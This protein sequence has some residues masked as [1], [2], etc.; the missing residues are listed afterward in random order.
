MNGCPRPLPPIVRG[1]LTLRPVSEPDVEP[2]ARRIATDPVTARWWSP[3]FET[4]LRWLREML[5]DEFVIEVEGDVAGI[6]AF[7][8]SHEPEYRFA[9]IDIALF[10]EFIGRGLGPLAIRTLGRWLIDECGHHR[11]TIDPSVDNARAIRAYEKVGF[12]RIGVLR[13]YERQQ[14]GTWGDNLY[15]DLLA[16]EL[17]DTDLDD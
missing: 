2:L 14:D 3:V 4:N 12:R 10:G 16:E 8:D 5:P 17:I 9:A 1:N 6:I 7:E 15:M 13:S 11:L